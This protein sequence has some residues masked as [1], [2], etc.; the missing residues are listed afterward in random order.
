MLIIIPKKFKK[1]DK[2]LNEFFMFL[3]NLVPPQRGQGL[4]VNSKYGHLVN[5][6]EIFS[7]MLNTTGNSNINIDIHNITMLIVL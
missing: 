5:T 4:P 7:N 1:Y 3:I 6:G 2:S